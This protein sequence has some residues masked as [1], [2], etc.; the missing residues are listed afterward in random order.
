MNAVFETEFFCSGIINVCPLN[1]LLVEI[2]ILN[3]PCSVVAWN[4]KQKVVREVFELKIKRY[5]RSFRS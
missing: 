2:H 1:L 4:E 5:K 3:R